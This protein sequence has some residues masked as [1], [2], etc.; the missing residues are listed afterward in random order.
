MHHSE[1][2]VSRLLILLLDVLLDG[3]RERNVARLVAL[4]YLA[5][6]FADDD[7]MIVFVYYLHIRGQ[8]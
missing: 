7:D 3:V 1:K 5:S 4:H 6:G 8:N 2:H